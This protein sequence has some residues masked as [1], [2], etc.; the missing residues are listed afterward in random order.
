MTCHV[1]GR[2]R[3]LPSRWKC[4]ASRHGSAGASPSQRYADLFRGRS[5][6]YL[7]FSLAVLLGLVGA[8]PV[9]SQSRL[10]K[11]ADLTAEFTRL[12]LMPQSQGPETC[13][14]HAVASLAAFEL[15][16]QESAQDHQRSTQFLI[17]ATRKETGKKDD[18]AMFYEAVDALNS[19]GS[20]ANRSFR[21]PRTTTRGA[22]P[23]GRLGRC[24]T[25]KQPLEGPLDQT[26]G[27]QT[28]AR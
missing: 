4:E 8:A 28:T 26:L 24:Q 20:V 27:P 2:A 19:A 15:A 12:G 21:R 13:S 22:P 25:A 5:C 9:W 10:P 3:L 7:L 14:L 6:G 16:K 17:W 18:Q 23:G 1:L 11:S